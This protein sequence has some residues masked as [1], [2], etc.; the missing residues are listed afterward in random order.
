MNPAQLNNESRRDKGGTRLVIVLAMASAAGVIAQAALAGTFLARGHDHALDIH[1]VLGPLLIIPTLGSAILT[2]LRVSP[3]A[4]GAR[5][6]RAAVGLTVALLVETALGFLS[7][8][9]PIILAFHI[10]V[11]VAIFGMLAI[12]LH[13]LRQVATSSAT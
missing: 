5:A 7:D 8:H 9:H 10:P 3:T 1:Q 11:A 12:Q 6:Y 4:A 13:Y 2:R